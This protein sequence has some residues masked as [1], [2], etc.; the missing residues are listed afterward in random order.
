MKLKSVSIKNLYGQYDFQ[1]DLSS[2][3]NILSGNNGSYKSTI[4]K[5]IFALCSLRYPEAYY[6][7]KSAVL[8][9]ED[10][11]QLKYLKF[12]D[13]ILRLKKE[14]QQDEMLLALAES[15]KSEIQNGN[16]KQLS[17][18]VLNADILN[19][20][21]KNERLT[22]ERF[23]K[24]CIVNL[25]STFDTPFKMD[26]MDASVIVNKSNLDDLLSKLE[27]NYA[28][29]L[30]DLSK[31]LTHLIMKQENFQRD[32]MK[33]IFADNEQFISMVDARF[34]STGKSVDRNSSRLQFQFEDGTQLDSLTHLSSGEKQMLV[35]LL[36]VLLQNHRESILIMDEPEISM[37]LDWQLELLNQIQKMNPNCQ[38]LLTTHSPGVIMEGWQSRVKNMTN[39]LSKLNNKE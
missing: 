21:R 4:I 1:W 34:K 13:S 14:A 28:Y 23:K 32:D 35:I 33:G 17:D 5:I 20:R 22:Q 37:H 8:E 29:Y 12:N 16:E 38:I 10:G 36:T 11:T 25:V 9:F 39:L 2:D 19:I 6:Q 18:H 30:S 27:S 3:V 26:K 15:V 7:I 31:Q 24:A